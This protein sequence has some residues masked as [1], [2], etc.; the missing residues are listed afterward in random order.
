MHAGFGM[1]H[2]GEKNKT[3][4]ARCFKISM[5]GFRSLCVCLMKTFSWL[6]PVMSSNALRGNV[7]APE[8]PPL[9]A[10]TSRP[11]CGVVAL[12][13]VWGR[14]CAKS[15]NM[16]IKRSKCNFRMGP[17]EVF[18]DVQFKLLGFNLDCFGFILLLRV[19]HFQQLCHVC[20]AQSRKWNRFFSP[21]FVI[22][23]SH[24]FQMTRR[25][26][27]DSWLN[28]SNSTRKRG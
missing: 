15:P 2:S 11:L 4:L 26:R 21:P 1:R 10:L 7:T 22:A 6:I 28:N 18:G 23:L 17:C 24:R 19:A 8:E 16:R 5:S 12:F 13:A 14:R 25:S 9:L 27:E 3:C 20:G